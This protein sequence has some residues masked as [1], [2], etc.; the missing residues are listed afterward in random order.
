HRN[1]T[2]ASSVDPQVFTTF[3]GLPDGF[4]RSYHYACDWYH[5]QG[6]LRSIFIRESLCSNF[7]NITR[8]ELFN[9]C[10]DPACCLVG[11][12]CAPSCIMSPDLANSASAQYLQRFVQDIG[13]AREEFIGTIPQPKDC[14]AQ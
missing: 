12:Q 8:H 14:I 13:T 10:T 9:H 3:G 11:G 2:S 5:S 6:F 1:N 7:S 4:H